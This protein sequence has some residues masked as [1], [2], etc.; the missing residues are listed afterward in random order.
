VI[1]DRF[2]KWDMERFEATSSSTFNLLADAGEGYLL[3]QVLVIVQDGE[4]DV[5]IYHHPEV[6]LGPVRV[7]SSILLNLD[8]P[9]R[10]LVSSDK[11]TL[12]TASLA[13]T[14]GTIRIY[15]IFQRG[16]YQE[17]S[18]LKGLMEKEKSLLK[19][20]WEVLMEPDLLTRAPEVT[21]AAV[22]SAPEAR[23]SLLPLLLVLAA[24]GGG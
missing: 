9:S 22:P 17:A 21:A 20:A 4:W 14:T 23:P 19:R 12:I 6:D 13:S 5:S 8:I 11:G 18:E 3:A 2:L 10:P 15:C 16:S 1:W 7:D 24:A